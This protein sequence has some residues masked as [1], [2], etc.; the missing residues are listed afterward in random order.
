M[1]GPQLGVLDGAHGERPGHQAGEP[2]EEQHARADAG[3][4]EPLADPGRR[5]NAVAGLRDVR[6]HP[7]EDAAGHLQPTRPPTPPTLPTLPLLTTGMRSPSSI[8]LVASSLP[9]VY[10]DRGS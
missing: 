8:A 2:G 4:G 3:P 9:S 7:L 1:L 6:T 5:Q 10:P